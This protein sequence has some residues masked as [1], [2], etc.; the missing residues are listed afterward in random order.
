MLGLGNSLS[1]DTSA[2]S[3]LGGGWLPSDEAKL[4]AWYRFG[5]G[6]TLNGS[7]VSVWADSSSNSF[8]M[9]NTDEDEQPAYSAGVLTFDPTSDT[10]NLQSTS[11]I[12]LDAAFVLGFRIDP[13]AIGGI[14][15]GSNS[16]PNEMLKLQADTTLRVK[17]DSTTS[18]YAL[19]SGHDTKDDS[20]WVISRDSSNNMSVY[21]DG[22]LQEAAK[23]NA[24]TFD[25]NSLG[26][27]R[28][29][30]NPY[31]GT[32]KEVVI[33]KGVPDAEIGALRSNL[34]DRLSG[35]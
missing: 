30:L 6:V 12:T 5:E 32:M 20:Y 7:N 26:V 14:V 8:D 21:K 24:G 28:T 19:E 16:D 18:N 29:D 23:T 4:E 13:A 10:E 35:L 15:L 3:A 34:Q 33:F 1:N 17:N 27:R 11:S 22:V 9:R 2:R 31:N 25:I